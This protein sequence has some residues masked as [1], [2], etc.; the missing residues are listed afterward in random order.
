LLLTHLDHIE[1]DLDLRNTNNLA[2][3]DALSVEIKPPR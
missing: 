2:L 3:R 1:A